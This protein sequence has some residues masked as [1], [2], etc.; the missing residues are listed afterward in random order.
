MNIGARLRMGREARGL[1]LLAL[2]EALRV[3]PKYL[4]AIEENDWRAIPPRPYGRGF[5]RAYAA[6]IGENPEQTVRDFFAQFAP[7][8]PA[9]NIPERRRAVLA[10]PKLARMRGG[11]AVAV[12]ACV[13]AGLVLVAALRPGRTRETPATDAVGTSGTAAPV[14]AATDL[15]A[16]PSVEAAAPVS[17]AIEAT[18]PAWVTASV[19]GRRLVYRTLQPGERET[20]RGRE[21]IALRVGDAGAIRLQINGGAAS[22]MGPSGAVRSARFTAQ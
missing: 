13:I 10:H 9:A 15:A 7:P 22:M 20:L 4:A 11:L 1:S 6:Y 5:V 17:V 19:D 2:A 3:Q 8:P 14:P 12:L 21:N 16:A 18:A